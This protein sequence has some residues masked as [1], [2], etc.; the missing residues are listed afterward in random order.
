MVPAGLSAR[1]VPDRDW[2]CLE[3]EEAGEPDE[4]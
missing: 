1:D 4:A 2:I 3:C